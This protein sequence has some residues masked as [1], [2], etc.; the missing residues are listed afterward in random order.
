MRFSFERVFLFDDGQ[1]TSD[2]KDMY[3][4]KIFSKIGVHFKSRILTQDF[5]D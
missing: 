1:L 3:L 4:A 2:H 5:D